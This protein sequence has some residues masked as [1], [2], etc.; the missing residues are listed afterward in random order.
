M[1]RSAARTRKV[2]TAASPRKGRRDTSATKKARNAP[3]LAPKRSSKGPS[4]RDT[5]DSMSTYL[6]E[7]SAA[8]RCL[9]TPKQEIGLGRRIVDRAIDIVIERTEAAERLLKKPGETAREEIDGARKLVSDFN[10]RGLTD[11]KALRKLLLKMYFSVTKAEA[12]QRVLMREL[13]SKD[14]QGAAD[15]ATFVERNLRLV[16]KV[17]SRYRYFEP[18][19]AFADIVQDGNIGLR[20]AALRFDYRRGIRFSTFAVWWIRHG[21]SRA[22]A[23][24]ART[25]R[26]PVHLIEALQKLEKLR[27]AMTA[28]LGR[29]PT[30]EEL[31]LATGLPLDGIHKILAKSQHTHSLDAPINHDGAQD[32]LGSIVPDEDAAD[33]VAL[34]IDEAQRKRLTLAMTR[35]DERHADVVRRRYGFDGEP[36]TLR[37]I[38]ESYG[39]SR[40]RARQL[41]TAALSQL[42]KA[43]RSP[44][45]V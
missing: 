22:Y 20:E 40:E 30:I 16:F 17:A 9:L 28:Q 42:R 35:L 34:L 19:I 10:P 45:L 39:L 13:V 32:T 36:Q 44:A 38:G 11:R 21:T 27:S 26:L 5:D 14:P 29:D 23:D 25:V 3:A 41:E 31:A 4:R 1:K 15:I 37:E 12:P 18:G 6:R 24:T 33:P 8:G 2:T 7:V 43:L